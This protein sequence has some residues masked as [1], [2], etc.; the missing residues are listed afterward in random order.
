MRRPRRQVPCATVAR[1]FGID[2][3]RWVEKEI[4]WTARKLQRLDTLCGAVGRRW[5][6]RDRLRR[7]YAD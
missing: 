3:W 1:V 4:G 5:G 6:F 2:I 7:W